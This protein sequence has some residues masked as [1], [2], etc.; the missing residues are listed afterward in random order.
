[1]ATVSRL[2]RLEAERLVGLDGA[3]L[4]AAEERVGRRPCSTSSGRRS[5]APARRASPCLPGLGASG[6]ALPVDLV[7]AHAA[8]CMAVVARDRDHRDLGGVAAAL[9]RNSWQRGPK[10]QPCGRSCG[11]GKLPG[12]RRSAAARS[13]RR[14]AAGSSGTAPAYRGGASG[15]RRRV[16]VPVST[17]SPEY[18]TRDAVAGLEDQAEIVAIEEHRGAEL[19]C[20][21]P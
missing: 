8:R 1:M 3:P 13:C 11:S 14:R 2:A 16:I 17:A 9:R 10:L 12:N 21:A 18:I 20:R 4:A 19:A 6:G 15:R 7:E 5:R